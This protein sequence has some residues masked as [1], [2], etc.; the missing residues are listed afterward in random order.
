MAFGLLLSPVPADAVLCGRAGGM[1]DQYCDSCWNCII[2][3]ND[4]ASHNTRAQSLC[5][6]L[7]GG[8]QVVK[9]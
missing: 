8:L 1:A 7:A 5:G 4:A 9:K 6:N 2:M 3:D